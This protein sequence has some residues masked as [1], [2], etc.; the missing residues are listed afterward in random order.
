MSSKK[1]SDQRIVKILQEAK[2]GMASIAEICRRNNVSEASFYAW[3]KQYEGLQVREV[4]R[5]RELELENVRLKKL[6]AES[7]LAREAL[8]EVL[9]KR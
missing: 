7:I 1:F 2:E 3:R 9:K 6:L 5:L 4:R 8:T